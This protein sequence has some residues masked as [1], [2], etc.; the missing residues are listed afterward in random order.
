MLHEKDTEVHVG[1]S[2]N[3]VSTFSE[4]RRYIQTDKHIDRRFLLGPI[5][6]TPTYPDYIYT[7]EPT[8]TITYTHK[9]AQTHLFLYILSS[10]G[11][12]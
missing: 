11:R 3:T 12:Q 8:S 6:F 5:T 10:F 1:H 2:V 9:I 4:N 7:V